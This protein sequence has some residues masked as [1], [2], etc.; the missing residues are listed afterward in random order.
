M[1]EATSGIF[2]RG[3]PGIAALTRATDVRSALPEHALEDRVDM[4][5]VVAEVELL[6]DLGVGEIFL[7]F[8]V[9]LQELEEVAF[10]APDWHGVA[11]HELVGVLAVRALLRQRQQHA[12]RMHEAAETVE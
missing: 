8:S 11:L 7:H 5:E 4:L 6:L 2:V 10:A 12:L 9:L 1:S 3:F